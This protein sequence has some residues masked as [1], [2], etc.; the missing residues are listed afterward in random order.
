MKKL[1]AHVRTH[2]LWDMYSARV[3]LYHGHLAHA[4]CQMER[5]LDCYRIATHLAQKTLDSN[6]IRGDHAHANLALANFIRVAASAGEIGLHIGLARQKRSPI[7]TNLRRR[8]M[9]VA[10]EC[11]LLK[12][13]LEAVGRVLEACLSD[14]IILAKYVAES[15]TFRN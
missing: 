10:Q 1:V 14:E 3:T 15:F 6:N 13:T 4:L 11:R 7:S 12:G 2:D 5:A 8:G 9:E